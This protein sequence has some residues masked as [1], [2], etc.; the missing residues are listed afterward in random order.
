MGWEIAV[1]AAVS[2]GWEP[3]VPTKEPE[4]G[5]GISEALLVVAGN[6]PQL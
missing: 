6:P 4:R 5:C 1:L 2:P 3:N